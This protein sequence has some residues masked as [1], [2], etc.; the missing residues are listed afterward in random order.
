MDIEKFRR[1][2]IG[3]L[4]PI[5]GEHRGRPFS[6]YAFV[7]TDLPPEVE[8][9]APTLL[10]LS[11]AATAVGRLDGAGRRLPNPHLLT[12]PSIRRE[13]VSTSALEGTYTTLPQI[14]QSELFEDEENPSR[15]VDEV[16][17]YVR[18]SEEA[19]RRIGDHPLSLNLIRDVH[20]ILLRNDPKVS[21]AEKG[22]FR[23]RQNFIGPQDNRVED[24]F[25][26]PPPPGD[27][28]VTGLHR[29]EVWIHREDIP[30]LVRVAIGHYQFETLH[31]FVDGNGRIGRLI[32]ALMLLESGDLS[33][34]LL[35]ISPYLEARRDEYQHRLRDLSVTGDYDAWTGFFLGALRSS[36]ET[37][38]EKSEALLALRDEMVGRLRE[39]RIR[40]T[41]IQATEDLIGDPVI[42]PTR[43]GK[44]YGVTYQAAVYTVNR[45]VEAGILE[46]AQVGSRRVFLATRVLELLE[47]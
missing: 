9:S 36:A 37:A 11:E 27:L 46:P 15:D 13:A 14:L 6:H 31:P 26:V 35:T 42:V 28:L 41:A 18:A 24:S 43:L 20:G 19:F 38:L 10:A 2:P 47:W 1:S 5:E 30:L 3:R 44:R 25:F 8:L 34:P 39:L 7:P 12:R 40:G 23:K 17:S 22:E 29:W 4:E 45:M 32:V 16:L 21:S 33:V